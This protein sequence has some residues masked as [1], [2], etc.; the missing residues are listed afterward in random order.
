MHINNIILSDFSFEMI[1]NIY[2]VNDNKLMYY[3]SVM[4]G[5]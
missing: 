4:N 3:H 2:H 1:T 5:L